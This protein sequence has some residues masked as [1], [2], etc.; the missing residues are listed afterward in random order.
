MK[1]RV[2]SVFFRSNEF[3]SNFNVFNK[4]KTLDYSVYMGTSGGKVHISDEAKRVQSVSY[5][6]IRSLSGLYT[7]SLHF[8]WLPSRYFVRKYSS[9]LVKNLLSTHIII[10]EPQQ[11]SVLCLQR[12]PE[13]QLQCTSRLLCF[14]R[15]RQQQL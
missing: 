1:N 9:F 8:L 14:Q 2:K 13:E 7:A 4:K 11:N 5:S 12:G 6:H 10:S 15:R 3:I